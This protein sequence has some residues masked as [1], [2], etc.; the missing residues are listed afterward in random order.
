MITY[1]DVSKYDNEW[2][3]ANTDYLKRKAE[4]ATGDE[5]EFYR[6]VA[7]LRAQLRSVAYLYKNAN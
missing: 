7:L 2:R 1:L 3:Q 6:S 5:L 4:G